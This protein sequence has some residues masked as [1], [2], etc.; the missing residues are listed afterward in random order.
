MHK[1]LEQIDLNGLTR[2]QSYGNGKIYLTY[3]DNRYIEILNEEINSKT[4]IEYLHKKDIN[5]TIEF[6]N[7]GDETN[8]DGIER[9][10]MIINI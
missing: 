10:K 4:I 5:F 7:V 6:F 3:K 2:I 9:S 8:D 1:D